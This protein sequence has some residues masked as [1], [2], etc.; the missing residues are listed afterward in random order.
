MPLI[1]IDV[2][3]GALDAPAREA[4]LKDVTASVLKVEGL[5]DTAQSRALTWV[6]VREA[7]LG[8]WAVG[9]VPPADLHFLVRVTVPLGTLSVARRRRMGLE[10][11]RVLSRVK[12]RAL[13]ADEAWI[14]LTEIPEDHWTAE[15]KVLRLAD[16]SGFTGMTA[17]KRHPRP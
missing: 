17:P 2:P 5:P 16:I 12:G 9:G 3:A 6:F 7:A 14:I 13:K 4:L 10:L 8:T 15:G 1:E 11:H